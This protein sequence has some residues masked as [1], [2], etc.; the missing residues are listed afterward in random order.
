MKFPLGWAKDF[1]DLPDDLQVISDRLTY[2][3][4]MTEHIDRVNPAW[5]EK[6]TAE[7]AERSPSGLKKLD[8]FVFRADADPSFELRVL[9]PEA[10]KPQG[11]LECELRVGQVIDVSQQKGEVFDISLDV[12]PSGRVRALAH[13]F[14]PS[15]GSKWATLL[16][17]VGTGGAKLASQ[18][19]V[20]YTTNSAEPVDLP[21][22]YETGRLLAEEMTDIVFD[23]EVRQN[24]PD[25]LG[26]VGLCRDLAASLGTPFRPAAPPNPQ[27]AD[28]D[29]NE[30]CSLT[31]EA[32]D[33][34][35]RFAI[36]IIRD[37]KIGPSPRW[38][39]D[40][41]VAGGMRSINN[42]VDVTNYVMLETGQPLHAFD[43]DKLGNTDILV[44][45]ARPGEKMAAIDERTYDLTDDMLVVGNGDKPLALAGIIG[46]KESE[47]TSSTA[48]IL[49][50]AA[51]YNQ[52][53][54]RKTSRKLAIRTE[55]STRLEKYLDPEGVA[56]AI[57]RAT[58]MILELGGGHCSRTMLDH[59]D[60]PWSPTVIEAEP[61]RINALLGTQ[62]TPVQMCEYLQRLE[63]EARLDD[64]RL[65]V[66]VPSWR[67]DVTQMADV[68]EEVARIYGY[69]NIPTQMLSS[70]TPPHV[71]ES[72][73][74]FDEGLRDIMTG[75]GLDEVITDTLADPEVLEKAYAAD[76]GRKPRLIELQNPPS[77]ELKALRP[78][79][80]YNLL[81]TARINHRAG[82]RRLAFFE[83]GKVFNLG[84][85]PAERQERRRLGVVLA[86][87]AQAREWT[88][89][90]MPYDVFHAK[91][92]AEAVLSTLGITG[93]SYEPHTHPMLHPGRCGRILH[94]T[95]LLGLFG[96]LHPRLR[97]LLGMK[98]LDACLLELDVDLL[99]ELAAPVEDY[100]NEYR[101]EAITADLNIVVGKNVPGADLVEAISSRGGPFLR[102]TRIIDLYE[103]E[104]IPADKKSVTFSL[105]FQTPDRTL[106]QAEIIPAL[107]NIK[108]GL[109]ERFE[110]AIRA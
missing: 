79:L 10:F 8:W 64:G 86:G 81:E 24:R 63:F 36:Q 44:R 34:C 74:S 48:N 110:A 46:G 72:P 96:Q 106:Q 82:R 3:G 69:E 26:V 73:R 101:H 104:R 1:M 65:T 14:C 98:V 77:K 88:G 60:P 99:E 42:V 66:K 7:L 95:H 31:V 6:V 39:A 93:A 20:G 53:C 75:L 55:A 33:L 21:D 43:Y 25:C 22:Y 27:P 50:D 71:F 15:V 12:G 13:K 94:H 58:Q 38:L 30:F 52:T 61:Q 83:V 23:L 2:T 59:Y 40:R 78:D 67:S 91:G 84:P 29:A 85:D 17:G 105:R 87:A 35:R 5:R 47:I 32:P 37:V 103:G 76:P 68:A 54:I 100:H 97:K 108:A 70:E 41:V 11:R 90:E 109:A 18:A 51:H 28:L 9:A 107:E 56:Q 45:R 57:L 92:I 89:A 19:D 102:S 4:Y 16:V 49:L 80:M 62:F